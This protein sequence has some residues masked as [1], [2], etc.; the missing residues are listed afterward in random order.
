MH[1]VGLS[2]LCDFIFQI[3]F[4][5]PRKRKQE[6]AAEFKEYEIFMLAISAVHEAIIFY[7]AAS[8]DVTLI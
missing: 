5:H 7:S 8:L 3:I 1:G 4:Y 6:E 2:R